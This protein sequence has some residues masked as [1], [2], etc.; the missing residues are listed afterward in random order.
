MV[1]QPKKKPETEKGPLYHEYDSMVHQ[2]TSHLRRVHASLMNKPLMMDVKGFEGKVPV[3]TDALAVPG[4]PLY[5]Y[6]SK[7]KMYNDH[8]FHFWDNVMARTFAIIAPWFTV[9]SKKALDALFA[10][11]FEKY[12]APPIPTIFVLHL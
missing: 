11:H 8:F 1:R 12:V 3:K 9:D 4:M 6:H 7:T 2:Y 10:L 5:Y